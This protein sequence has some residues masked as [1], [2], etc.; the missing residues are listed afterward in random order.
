[1]INALSELL[2]VPAEQKEAR[3]ILYTPAE[4]AQQPA[5]WET[6][7]QRI[8]LNEQEIADFLRSA[9]IGGDDAAKPTIFLVGAGTSDYVGCALASLL[10]QRW[11]CEV[12]AIASTDLLGNMEG[13]LLP[14]RPYLWISFSRSG[15]SSEGVAVIESAIE[16]HPEI[17]HLVITCNKDGRMA[18]TCKNATRRLAI[19]LD[20]TVNDR[21]LA[22]TS[23]FSN[24]IVAG[25]SLAHIWSLSEYEGIISDLVRMGTAFLPMAAETASNIAAEGCSK[26]C[27]VGSG[28]LSAVA[29][30]S[31]LKLLELTAGRVCAMSE[32]TL[33]LRHG[34]MSALDDDTLFVSFLSTDPVRR[35]YEMDLLREI[36]SKGLGR[37]RLAIAPEPI[38][39]LNAVVDHA[40]VLNAPTGFGDDYRP[41]VDIILAQLLG[42]F[43]SIAA[44]L[45]PD[46][47]SPNGAISRVVSHVNIYS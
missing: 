26:A 46:C 35:K 7:Y 10:R 41:P 16:R 11:Q 18:K 24:M 14:G 32:S 12:M 2:S 42:L 19:V 28:A 3:G 22:M 15:D 6:T 45:K 40:F 29:R 37:I 13:F 38:P 4:I 34:P 33:G 1:L 27:F 23:S 30:E 43:S 36:R 21:G 25:Q 20:D 47:P 8:H 44:G 39:G 31:A 5:T 17:F 9:G